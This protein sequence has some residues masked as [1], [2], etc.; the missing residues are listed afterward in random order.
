MGKPPFTNIMQSFSDSSKT[1]VPIILDGVVKGFLNGTY[2][3]M[4]ICPL[5]YLSSRG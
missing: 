2:G 5:I 4:F 1:K 3:N